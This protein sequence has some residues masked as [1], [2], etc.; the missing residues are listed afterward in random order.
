MASALRSGTIKLTLSP[1]PLAVRIQTTNFLSVVTDLGPSLAYV[2]PAIEERLGR[3]WA[4]DLDMK[5][6]VRD[7]DGACAAHAARATQRASWL[8][9]VTCMSPCTLCVCADDSPQRLPT[10]P[11]GAQGGR[12]HSEGGGA[13]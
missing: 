13:L 5:V 9:T 7:L 11:G 4:Y 6:F 2:M 8:L 3:Q 12:A 10:R 1:S